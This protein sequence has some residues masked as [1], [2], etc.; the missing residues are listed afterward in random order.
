MAHHCFNIMSHHAKTHSSSSKT[1]HKPKT[2]KAEVNQTEIKTNQQIK[3][4]KIHH[5]Q[6]TETKSANGTDHAQA[7]SSN[8]GSSSG[9]SSSSITAV[10]E[11]KQKLIKPTSS[12]SG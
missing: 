5:K 12:S 10:Q 4:T 6:E 7:H 9:K 11:K 2:H 1:A 8:S 3:E